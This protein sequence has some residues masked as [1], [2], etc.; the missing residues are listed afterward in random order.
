MDKIRIGIAGYGNVARGVEK[1]V[2]ASPDMEMRAILTRRDPASVTAAWSGA[3]VYSVDDAEK[4]VEEIDVMVLCGGSAT[5]LK[6]QGP[7]FAALYNIV[8]SFD[9]HPSIPGYMAV[10]NEAARNTTAVISSGWDPG[11]FSMIRLMSHA[12]LPDG[13]S[14]TFWGSGV[15][16]G[17]SEAIRHIAGVRDAVQYTVP[18]DSA[19]SAVRGGSRPRLETR[20]KHERVCY[21]V[22]EPGADKAAIENEIKVMPYY[23]ADYDTTV[24]F[25]GDDEFKAGHSGMPHGGMVLHS[26]NTGE[27]GHMIE[28]SL[29]LDSNPEFTGSVMAACARA[30]YRLSREGAF[31][32]KCVFDFPLSYLS[33]KDR[34]TLIKELL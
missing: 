3:P 17:H 5:D 26:G 32:A 31:G 23:F 9:A 11:L 28:F 1:A 16:Q 22:A 14:Y 12:V 15:S 33:Y 10:I 29:K 19:V 24:N 21:V 18:L 25:I 30:A 6:H 7:M 27:N 2:A 20:Q 13:E 4:L 34:P 8:D